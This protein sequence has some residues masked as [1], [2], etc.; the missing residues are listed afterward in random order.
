MTTTDH[1]KYPPPVQ[2]R[3]SDDMR[4]EPVVIAVRTEWLYSECNHTTVAGSFSHSMTSAAE[5]RAR[6]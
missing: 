4:A 2:E 3:W 5:T 1:N 6:P